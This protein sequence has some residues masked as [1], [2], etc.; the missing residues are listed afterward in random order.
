MFYWLKKKIVRSFHFWRLHRKGSPIYTENHPNLY[1]NDVF[2]SNQWHWWFYYMSTLNWLYEISIK[3][4]HYFPSDFEWLHFYCWNKRKTNQLE[5]GTSFL[6]P[7]FPSW[8]S[9]FFKLNVVVTF[10]SSFFFTNDSLKLF[11]FFWWKYILFPKVCFRSHF[12]SHA[13]TF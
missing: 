12:K 8:F 3:N 5:F 1:I 7:F 10:F 2:L 4:T 6:G 9:H 13:H 11:R